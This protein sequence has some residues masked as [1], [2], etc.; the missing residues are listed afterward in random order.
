[1]VRGHCRFRP[2]MSGQSREKPVV[3]GGPR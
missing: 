1:M 3:N 2:A